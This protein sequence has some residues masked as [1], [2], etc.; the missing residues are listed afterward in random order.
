MENVY[1][2]LSLEGATEMH[3]QLLEHVN[4]DDIA[5]LDASVQQ[6]HKDLQQRC[7]DIDGAFS[8]F[9]EDK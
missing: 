9:K 7:M 6:L 5:H 8:K 2:Y 3:D 4:P 1:L